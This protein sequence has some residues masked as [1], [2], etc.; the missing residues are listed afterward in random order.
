MIRLKKNG[1]LFNKWYAWFRSRASFLKLIACLPVLVA[2]LTLSFRSLVPH[3]KAPPAERPDILLFIADDMTSR[4]CAPYGNPDVNTPNLSRLAKEGL[5]FDNMYNATAM[6]CPTRQSLYTGIFPVKNGAWPNHSKVYNDVTSIAHHFRSIGY[7][8]ALIGK[9]HYAPAASF[10]F[11]WLGGR[12]S[13]NGKGQD[14]NLADAETYINKDQSKPW[15]LIVATNQPHGP[16][17]RGNPDQYDPDRLTIPPYMVDTR[18]TREQLTKYYAEITY[19]DSLVGDC[20]KMVDRHGNKDNTLFIFTSEQGASFPFGKWTCYNM[21]LKAAFIARWPRVIKPSTRTGILSQYV[22]VAPSLYEAAGGH[23]DKLRGNLSG[24]MKLDGKSFYQAFKGSP[25]E[26]RDYVYGVQT[27]RGVNNGS[28]N[29]PVRSIQDQS[30]KLIWNLNY[31]T[32]FYN[33]ISRPE[34]TDSKGSRLYDEWLDDSK[35]NPK[36]HAHVKLYQS[37]PEFELYDM[38]RDP[39]ELDNLAGRSAE[40]V[41]IQEQLFAGLKKW[42]QQQGDRGVATEMKALTRYKGDSLK[43]KSATKPT[44]QAQ[45]G[46]PNILFIAVDDLKPLLGCYGDPDETV[47]TAGDKKYTAVVKDLNGKCSASWMNR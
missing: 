46:Q 32:K 3:E 23:P 36:E 8:V 34:S 37:R 27:T 43:W 5:C 15:L 10:P 18:H 17:N 33:A 16:W 25:A 12:N 30:Y 42:M 45:P 9:Q 29:Y 4:D 40:M 13:D 2:G 14:I 21:G 6:C 20:M 47:N 22:D 39:Y 41:K 28:L 35:D 44:A 24:T 26:V 7:R 1:S 19:A 31:K 38:N 11:E